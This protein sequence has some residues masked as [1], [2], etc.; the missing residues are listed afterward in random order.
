MSDEMPDDPGADAADAMSAP[1]PLPAARHGR[2]P[3]PPEGAPPWQR[4]A[5]PGARPSMDGR[6]LEAIVEALVFASPEPLTAKMLFKLLADEPRDDVQAALDRL[7]ARLRASRRTAPGAGGR[8]LPDHDPA[9]AARLG[10]PSVSRAQRAEALGGGARDAVGHCLPAAG[11]GGRGERDSRRQRLGRALDAARAASHQDRRTQ[12]RGRPAV[13]LRHHQGVPDPLRA[14]GPGRSAEH[15]RTWCRR[16][17]SI[18]R[19]CSWSG[20]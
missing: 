15:A 5:R 7:I 16:S 4:R 6:Q 18:R 17:A 8:R 13:P 9:R 3:R 20:R 11:D 10:A 1:A 2:R 12:E 19:H 14:E